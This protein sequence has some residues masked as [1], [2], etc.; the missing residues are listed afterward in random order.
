MKQLSEGGQLPH[1]MLP[2]LL[3]DLNDRHLYKKWGDM[4]EI[5]ELYGRF[6]TEERVHR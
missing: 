1:S 2:H 6:S 4:L 3:F 5:K